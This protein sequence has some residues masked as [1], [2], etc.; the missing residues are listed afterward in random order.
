MKKI[1]LLFVFLYTGSVIFSLD[2][3]SYPEVIQNGTMILDAGVGFGKPVYDG[4]Q[5]PPVSLNF[6][7]ALPLFS[8][9]FSFGLRFA[10]STDDYVLGTV[11][12][13]GVA[14]RMAYHLNFGVPHLDTYTAI[15]IGDVISTLG[16]GTKNH[17]WLGWLV[18]ARYYFK[19]QSHF[20]AYLETGIS[21]LYFVSLGGTLRF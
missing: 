3:R 11:N 7:Y 17:V 13:F 10:Y 15:N 9:P 21:K 6:E 5:C 20:G 2:L 16:D 1:F 8:L 19:Y 4:M 14:F 18:G 12:N